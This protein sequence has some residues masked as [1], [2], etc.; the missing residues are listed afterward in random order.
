[1]PHNRIFGMPIM[2]RPVS[3]AFVYGRKKK[4]EAREPARA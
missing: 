3:R 1:L 2:P 4:L